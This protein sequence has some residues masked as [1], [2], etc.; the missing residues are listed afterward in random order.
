M[1]CIW[2]MK[3]GMKVTSIKKCF[4]DS[5]AFIALNHAY[6]KNHKSAYHIASKLNG[7]HFILSDAVVTETYNILRYRIGYEAGSRFL[8][9]T[10][11]RNE[12][13]I[14]IVTLTMRHEV[15][16][17]LEKYREHKISYCDALSVIIMRE[18]KVKNIFAFDHH[19]EMMGVSL[20]NH[21]V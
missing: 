17:L 5:S 14:A 18:N 19:F 7:F 4:I 8:E 21:V 2:W 12:Y 3:A 9:M 1:I 10:L 16:L 11:H 15:L 6:D 13:E 20:I